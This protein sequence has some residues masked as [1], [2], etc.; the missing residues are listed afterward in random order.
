MSNSEELLS[1]VSHTQTSSLG[2]ALAKGDLKYLMDNL[3]IVRFLLI[4]LGYSTVIV[5]CAILVKFVRKKYFLR[6]DYRG[7]STLWRVL[8]I[9]AVGQPEYSLA[10]N[11]E[12]NTVSNKNESRE[13]KELKSERKKFID[14][15]LM[16]SFYF[17]GIQSNFVVMGFI[18]E[19]IMTQGYSTIGNEE[20]IEKFGDAQF[21]VLCNRIVALFFC[22]IIL[23]SIRRRQAPHVPPFYY[24]SY[25]SL[26]NTLSS[27]C[28]Y[29]A[30]KFVS[31]PTQTVCKASKVIPT[32]LMGRILRKEKYSKEDYA[33]AFCLAFGAAIFLLSQ[34]KAS[35]SNLYEHSTTVSGIILMA[36]YLGFDAYTL[37]KQKQLFD[38]KPK[39]SKYQ[40]MLG[41][42]LFSAVLCIVSLLEQSTLFTSIDFMVTHHNIARDAF[43]L[44]LS[45]SIGQIFIYMTIERF[46]P[47][48]FA[49]IM[50]IRQI[51]SIV[52]SSLYFNHGLSILGVIGLIIAFGSILFS[53]YRRYFADEQKKKTVTK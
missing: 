29:E 6:P 19:K 51:I 32:M 14:D 34:N 27:W 26:S 8:K 53:T 38:T 35:T 16:L 12:S 3:W 25:I 30:L 7:D 28:Q 31:F 39:L 9:F 20:I 1:S 36:G 10:T 21:L 50:T 43:L 48:V 15:C 52:L 49:V 40:M 24:H 22:S 5:P 42:N 2:E 13:D 41:V 45:G 47:I 4:L 46:G 23:Y 11:N 17:L 37:N 18:Q 44:S 33:M